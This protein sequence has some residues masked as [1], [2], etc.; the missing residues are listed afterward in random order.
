MTCISFGWCGGTLIVFAL[1]NV[2]MW[3]ELCVAGGVV[4]LITI[5]LVIGLIESPRWLAANHGMVAAEQALRALRPAD[6]RLEGTLA[7][8]AEAIDQQK[9]KPSQSREPLLPSG[10]DAPRS[11]PS[12]IGPV[13]MNCSSQCLNNVGQ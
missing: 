7:E 10:M 4:A 6:A 13:V 8:I 1:G 3:R 11:S 9:R 5:F 2:L 12:Q